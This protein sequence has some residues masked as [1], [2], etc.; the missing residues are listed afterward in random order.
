MTEDTVQRLM[1]L[2]RE[3][4]Q[5]EIIA[6]LAMGSKGYRPERFNVAGKW[7]R[8]ESAL[9]EALAAPAEV[10]AGARD[11]ALPP[12][13]PL[14]QAAFGWP[15]HDFG[16]GWS[17][18]QVMAFAREYGQ[19]CAADTG[20]KGSARLRWLHSPPSLDVDGYEWGIFRVK[21]VN[22]QAAEVWQTNADFSDLDA[23]MSAPTPQEPKP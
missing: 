23:A 7:E 11:A 3:A 5:E 19:M 18:R 13:P 12:L 20:R 9:R 8:L 2:A 14:P 16:P 10:P 6:G 4:T 15:Q 21:W 17:E 22:G 1:G